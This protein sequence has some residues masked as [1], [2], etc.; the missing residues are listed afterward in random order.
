MTIPQNVLAIDAGQ[1]GIKT[2]WG[3]A[4]PS[5]DAVFPGIRTHAPLLPQLAEVVRAVSERS[6]RTPEVVAAGVSGLTSAESDASALRSLLGPGVP[7]RTL[8]AHDATA[9]YL[10]ALGAAQGAVIA[11]GTGV[12]TLAVGADAVAR[13]DGWGY[14]IGDIGSG[15]WLGRAALEAAMR[16]YDGRGPATALRAVAE[17]RW[18]DLS[19]AYILL[20]TA[21]DRVSVIAGFARDVADLAASDAVAA[22]ITRRAADELAHSVVTALGRVRPGDGPTLPVCAL[23][24]VFR[25]P[26]LRLEFERRLAASSDVELVDPRGDGLDGALALAGLDDRHP[27]FTAVS[28]SP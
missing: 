27:L 22:D 6:G 23:G 14:L 15:Y 20:Q 16:D 24:N 12:V 25:S 10:G 4:D 1:T 3:G 21:E 5:E 17:A 11:A 7:A 9:A 13:V 8:L 2:R 18:A 28:A 19:E 26:A